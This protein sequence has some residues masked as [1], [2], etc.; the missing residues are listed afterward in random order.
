MIVLMLATAV[1]MVIALTSRQ[2]GF[3]PNS[4]SAI[5]AG[6]EEIALDVR[7]PYK[8]TLAINLILYPRFSCISP[9]L[10][11]MHYHNSSLIGSSLLDAVIKPEDYSIY[12]Q[13]SPR[14]SLYARLVTENVGVYNYLATH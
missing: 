8:C 1:I 4:V 10:L 3:Q 5:L 7:I 2:L 9:E 14:L 12:R 6:L 11:Q 13:L